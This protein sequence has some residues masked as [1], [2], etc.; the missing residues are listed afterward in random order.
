MNAEMIYDVAIIGAGGAGQMAMLRAALNHLKTVIYL[1]DAQ[2]T[3]KG[4]A[5]WVFDVDNIPGMFGRKRPI[6]STTKEVLQFIDA[7]EKLKPYLTTVKRA[8]TSVRKADGL[9]VLSDGTDETRARFVVLCTGTM[10]VQPHI[11]GSIEP[12]LPFA[13]KGDVL[14]CIRCD[15][16]RTA[17]HHCAVIGHGSGAGW[18]AV[19]LKERYDLPELTVMTHGHAFEG[20]DEVRALMEKYGIKLVTGEITEVIGDA[21]TGLKGFRVGDEAV[22]VTKSFVALGS[23]VYNA[24]AKQL[25]VKLSADDHVLTDDKGETSVPG[26]FAA[27]DLVEGKKKQVYTAWDM[28]VD[29]VDAIDA[30]IRLQKRQASDQT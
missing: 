15:G 9:F 5:T 11:Q 26:F 16:H 19:M 28:A 6:T 27:G 30:R 14:Y 10:D 12:I 23:I 24:L 13:N 20:S 1:G 3:K 21:K 4:R 7:D 2:T 8:V 18:I 22:S 29:A 25:N 17:G